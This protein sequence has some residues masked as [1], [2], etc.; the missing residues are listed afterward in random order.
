MFWIA[1]A[2]VLAPGFIATTIFFHQVYLVELRGWSLQVFASAFIV[3]S[4]MTMLSSLLSGYLIDRFSAVEILPYHL[5]PLAVACFVLAFIHA[6]WSAFAFMTLLGVSLGS[7]STLFG[8]LWP[9]MYGLGHLGGIR[10]LIVALTVFATA[11]GPGLTGL[12]IDVGVPYPWQIA[13]MGVYCLGSIFVMVLVRDR[14]QSRNA[15]SLIVDV[16]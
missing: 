2:V 7:S 1:L 9:E 14:V 5:L 4:T 3:S 12:L 6:Q 15:P 10:A 8:A 13:G 16:R 11:I